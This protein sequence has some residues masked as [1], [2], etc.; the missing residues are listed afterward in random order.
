MIRDYRHQLLN[1]AAGGGRQAVRDFV[2][3]D[4]AGK[5]DLER[6]ALLRG[7]RL[8]MESLLAQ[9]SQLGA[10]ALVVDVLHQLE[11]EAAT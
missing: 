5:P 11:D 4:L 3:S 10:L 7:T 1:K 2:V 6:R 9:A 8:E